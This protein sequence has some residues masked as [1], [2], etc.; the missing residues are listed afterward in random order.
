MKLCPFNQ[1]NPCKTD[2]CALCVDVDGKPVCSIAFIANELFIIA[3]S[4]M[5]KEEPTEQ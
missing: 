4:T 3:D 5:A 2:E 1:L